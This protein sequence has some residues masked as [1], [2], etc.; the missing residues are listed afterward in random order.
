MT[1]DWVR[2]INVIS[3]RPL[4]NFMDRASSPVYNAMKRA[5]HSVSLILTETLEAGKA[6]LYIQKMSIPRGKY[7]PLHDER[8]PM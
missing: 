3:M 1:G 8:H 5:S 4:L 7:L 6:I 2:S